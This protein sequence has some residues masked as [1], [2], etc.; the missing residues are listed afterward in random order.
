MNIKPSS[1]CPCFSGS[2]YRDCCQPVHKAL[3]A[4]VS[5]EKMMRSRYSAFALGLVDYLVATLDP[6]HADAK[7]DPAALRAAM[8]ASA[9]GHK[10]T[11]LRILSVEDGEEK[12]VVTFHARLFE[13][14]QDRSFTER[15]TFL[16][17][18]DKW[19]YAVGEAEP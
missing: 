9:R 19:L 4:G 3:G 15:S 1:K 13:K 6:T 14:G 5:A 2:A 17:R 18:G 8:G 7:L 10:Y 12:S 11:G 16:R